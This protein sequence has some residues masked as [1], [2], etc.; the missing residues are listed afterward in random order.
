MFYLRFFRFAS[1][2]TLYAFFG[3]NQAYMQ[4]SGK[5]RVFVGGHMQILGKFRAKVVR[6]ALFFKEC[7]W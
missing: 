6:L 1:K 7:E 2:R 5:I 4:I 3:Q